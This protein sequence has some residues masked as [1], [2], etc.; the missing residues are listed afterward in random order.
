MIIITPLGKILRVA[1]KSYTTVKLKIQ[2]ACKCWRNISQSHAQPSLNY[3]RGYCQKSISV[4]AIIRYL[5]YLDP[6]SYTKKITRASSK[7]SKC[8]TLQHL[9]YLLILP[10]PAGKNNG[11]ICCTR[12]TGKSHV[13]SFCAFL[14]HTHTRAV[15]SFL[16]TT[17][18]LEKAYVICPSF[19]WISEQ[20]Q[21]FIICKRFLDV[22]SQSQLF[23][24][25]T[26]A[27]NWEC[28]RYIWN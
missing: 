11:T 15:P 21:N 12:T 3:T 1:F 5:T 27:V 18:S 8:Y 26:V 17:G 6:T 24:S 16:P 19:Q 10:H 22:W 20:R 13:L 4:E 25:N 2:Q 7:C 9:S 14:A 23:H 28:S